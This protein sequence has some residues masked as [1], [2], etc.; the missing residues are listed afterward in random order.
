MARIALLRDKIEGVVLGSEWE[1]CIHGRSA[2]RVPN[3]SYFGFIG[4]DALSLQYLL[5]SRGIQ[6]SVGA[7]CDS[8]IIKPSRVLVAM[9]S[10]VI[11]G[12]AIRVSLS[13]QTTKSQIRYFTDNLLMCIPLMKELKGDDLYGS[14]R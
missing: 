8:G 2:K 12:K 10:P 3:T 13:E 4:K 11:F 6:V 9:K 14:I 1:A 7:A 5:E